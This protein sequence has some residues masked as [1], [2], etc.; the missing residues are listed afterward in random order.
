MGEASTA[1]TIY[2]LGY[3]HYEGTRLGRANAIGTLTAYSLRSAFGIGRGER[4]KLVPVLLGLLAFAPAVV[5]IGMANADA[6]PSRISFVQQFQ[7]TTFFLVLFAAAQVPELIVADR[8]LGILSL[9]LSRSLR[10]TDYALAKLLAMTLALLCYT[11]L[12]LLVLFMGALFVGGAP[13]HALGTHWKSLGPI[14]G[15]SILL[16]LYLA[17]VGLALGSLAVRKGYASAAVIAFF[18]ML[19]VIAGLSMSL[20][21]AH[22]MGYA[23]LGNP[24][25]TVIGFARWAFGQHQ[26]MP[27]RVPSWYRVFGVAY[28]NTLLATA[29][30]AVGLLLA[31]YRRM[32]V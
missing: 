31:R 12:P 24:L 28:M 22:T 19:P 26:A 6:D 16:S 20:L 27:R 8:Q 11:L 1:G 3:Q 32:S 15:T 17:S 2:D 10:A 13:G 21:P 18:L 7:F 9:Y 30:V 4:A 14:F 29:V 5:Q 23:V 25:Q